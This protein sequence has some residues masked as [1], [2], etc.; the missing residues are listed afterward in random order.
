M[1]LQAKLEQAKLD[2]EAITANIQKLEQEIEDNKD[3]PAFE[4]AESEHTYDNKRLIMRYSESMARS[5]E[6]H[7]DMNG[8]MFT[9]NIRTGELVNHDKRNYTSDFYSNYRPLEDVL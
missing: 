5:I 3:R 6:K 7:L 9:F 8:G 4:L 1:N 2:R